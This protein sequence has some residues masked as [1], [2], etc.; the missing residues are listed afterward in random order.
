MMSITTSSTS[1][2]A[3][4]ATLAVGAGITAFAQAG[5]RP[6][7]REVKQLIEEIDRGRDRFEDQLDPKVKASIIRNEK[8]ELNVERYLDDLQD[9]LKNLKER[10]NSDYAA[11][12]EAEVVLRQSS[13]IHERV[14]SQPKEMKGGSEWD[15]MAAGLTRLAAAYGTQFPVPRDAVVRRFNDKETAD[16]AEE[17]AKN[18]E[19]LKKQIDQEKSL[20]PPVRDAGKKAADELTKQAKTVKSRV[21][22]SRPATAEMRSLLD[23]SRKMGDFMTSQRSL[24]P[25]TTGAWNAVQAPLGKLQQAYGIK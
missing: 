20:A 24:L 6:S 23:L 16:I 12:K 1:R 14:K 25:G 4:L 15:T 18:S 10:F 2:A 13:E 8:G 11:S 22:D 21:S 7:D 17:L 5:E 9:N 19:E 3:F